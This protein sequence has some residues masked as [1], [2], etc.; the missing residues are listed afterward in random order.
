M[1]ISC[2]REKE[3]LRFDFLIPINQFPSDPID[4]EGDAPYGPGLDLEGVASYGYNVQLRQLLRAVS[5]RRKN[6]HHTGTG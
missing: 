5:A 3:N 1:Y 6:A 2:V 4:L